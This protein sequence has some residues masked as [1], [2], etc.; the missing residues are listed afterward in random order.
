MKNEEGRM[1]KDG[2][3]EKWNG[4]RSYKITGLEEWNVGVNEW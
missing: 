2:K 3:L 1:K 4:G